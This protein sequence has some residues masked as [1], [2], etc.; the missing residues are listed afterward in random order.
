[1]VAKWGFSVLVLGTWSI[2]KIWNQCSLTHYMAVFR[3][4]VFVLPRLDAFCIWVYKGFFICFEKDW[5]TSL[6]YSNLF[7]LEYILDMNLRVFSLL[8]VV[9]M[10]TVCICIYVYDLLLHQN[11][12]Y[13]L[14]VHFIDY[15]CTS[16][17]SILIESTWSRWFWRIEIFRW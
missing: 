17:I 7:L 4:R 13:V 5:V 16:L 9:L 10:C 8:I 6:L 2:G 14:I 12:N 3:N 11:R 1:M 15:I